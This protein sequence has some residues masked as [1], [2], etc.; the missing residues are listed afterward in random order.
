MIGHGQNLAGANI[1]QHRR[2]GLG[3]ELLERLAQL[4]V[5]DVLQAQIQRQR[6]VVARPRVT[7]YL[8]ILDQPATAILQ[9]LTLAG[10]ALEPVVVGELQPFLTRFIDVGKANQMGGDFT[11]GIE[12]SI[13]LNAV[14][15]RHLEGDD[16]L[17][18]LRRHMPA[19]I[20]ELP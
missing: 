6:Q 3:A 1:H 9:Y 19:Q 8:D 11:G 4:T 5:G 16:L 2:S 17:T 18:I 14:D 15:T 12:A 10:Y 13:F 20:D 7:D